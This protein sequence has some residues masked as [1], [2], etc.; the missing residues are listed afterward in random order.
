MNIDLKALIPIQ[1]WEPF[2]TEVVKAQIDSLS[3]LA[4]LEPTCNFDV[5]GSHKLKIRYL[6]CDGEMPAYGRYL[7][8]KENRSPAIKYHLVEF[9]VCIVFDEDHINE[10][11]NAFPEKERIPVAKSTCSHNICTL[12][13]NILAVANLARP[14][15]L[16]AGEGGV[17][18]DGIIFR[19]TDSNYNNLMNAYETSAKNNWPPIGMGSIKKTWNWCNRIPGFAEGIGE[20]PC[21]RAI[22]AFSYLFKPSIVLYTNM[23]IVW[24]LL[25]LESIYCRG[26]IGMQHQLHGKIEAFL[27]KRKDNKKAIGRMYDFRSRFIHG[28]VTFPFQYSQYDEYPKFEGARD[29]AT[30][31][32]VALLISSLQKMIDKDI[33]ELDF[34]YIC[35]KE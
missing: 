28:D 33:L 4:V 10:Q 11:L 30:D 17:F 2:G 18:A 6:G 16:P 32:A 35:S 34:E 23:D 5:L 29:T 1:I 3:E 7:P 24:A 20:T 21:G 14:G 9:D 8:Y 13:S 19:G 31:E 22:A 25:G 12:I 26:N 27:G 15:L